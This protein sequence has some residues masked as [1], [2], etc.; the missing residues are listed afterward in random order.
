MNDKKLQ[1]C[2]FFSMLSMIT[3]L[4]ILLKFGGN[5][6]KC[7]QTLIISILIGLIAIAAIACI[8][9]CDKNQTAL[10]S[11]T[12]FVDDAGLYA[13]YNGKKK[14]TICCIQ[15]YDSIKFLSEDKAMPTRIYI[16]HGKTIDKEIFDFLKENGYEFSCATPDCIVIENQIEKGTEKQQKDSAKQ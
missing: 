9:C 16:K 7:C 11:K 4:C 3:V 5:E 10:C 14:G 1:A 15:Y 2:C 12:L 13:M 8:W 6:M